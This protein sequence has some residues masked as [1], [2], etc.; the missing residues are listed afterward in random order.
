MRS[1][2]NHW[3]HFEGFGEVDTNAT[4]DGCSKRRTKSMRKQLEWEAA[5][6]NRASFSRV[7]SFGSD[8]DMHLEKML[9]GDDLIDNNDDHDDDDDDNDDDVC[10]EAH[11][12]IAAATTAAGTTAVTTSSC[13]TPRTLPW[14]RNG[15]GKPLPTIFSERNLEASMFPLHQQQP[16]PSTKVA[17]DDLHLR[18]RTHPLPTIG[19]NHKNKLGAR[20]NQSYS[21][22]SRTNLH[23]DL[24][25]CNHDT[26]SDNNNNYNTATHHDV[27]SLSTHVRHRNR[28]ARAHYNARI[29]PDRLFLVR[30][31]QSQGNNDEHLYATTPDNAMPLTQLGW[32]QARQ[33]GR[34]LKQQL[35]DQAPH[36]IVSPYVRTVETF[37]GIVSAWCDP[38]EFNYIT[39]REQRIKAWYAKLRKLGLTWHEDPRIREQDFGN[40]QDPDKIQQAKRDRHRFGAFYY[41]FPYGESAS[42]VCSNV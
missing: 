11:H 29:M 5:S 32:E 21:D 17:L 36:F 31:G 6:R 12:L 14:R 1:H 41:R 9:E 7:S 20:R 8:T 2:S 40:Y 3:N 37:H 23:T 34:H 42:D 26:G 19:S 18:T 4:A 38:S 28:A 16:R 15:H 33:A 27:L 39:G 24:V 13:S 25:Q 30:H 22:L 35:Q 10:N